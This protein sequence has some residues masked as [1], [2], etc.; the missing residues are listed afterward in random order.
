MTQMMTRIREIRTTQ[1]ILMIQE[2]RIIQEIR[3]VGTIPAIQEIRMMK[4]NQ[5]LSCTI[6]PFLMIQKKDITIS[7]ARQ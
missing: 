2:I 4:Q 3:T 7:S 6:I 5:N 1:G